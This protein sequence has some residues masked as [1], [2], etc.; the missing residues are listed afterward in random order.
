MRA[1]HHLIWLHAGGAASHFSLGADLGPQ[2]G[3]ARA[4]R[5]ILADA[6]QLRHALWL[7]RFGAGMAAPKDAALIPLWQAMQD[8]RAHR[9]ISRSAKQ[10]LLHH[11]FG[12]ADAGA[13][14]LVRRHPDDFANIITPLFKQIL[15]I[16]PAQTDPRDGLLLHM[17]QPSVYLWAPPAAT[18]LIVCFTTIKSTLNAPLPLAHLALAQTGCAIAYVYTGTL[19][20]AQGLAPDW[21]VAA[22]AGLITDLADACGY[23]QVYALGASLGGYTACRYAQ[24][25]PFCRI[26]NFSGAA[27]RADE[28]LPPEMLPHNWAPAYDRRNILTVFARNDVTD[29]RIIAS[30]DACGFDTPRVALDAD[31]HGSFS[32]SWVAGLLPALTQW[33]L[34]DGPIPA[35]AQHIP[36]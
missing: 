13:L 3:R 17:A 18:R 26:L 10:R 21:D 22:C 12:Q 16:I 4:L 36:T 35:P 27:G 31:F 5:A 8:L 34:H 15:P 2:F 24:Q 19:H 28:T 32:A 6:P 1:S 25:L 11:A 14:D 7:R 29:G 20:P 9:L 30:Y 33:L 23:R